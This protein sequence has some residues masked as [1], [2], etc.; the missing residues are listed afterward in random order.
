MPRLERQ[1]EGDGQ[2]GGEPAQWIPTAEAAAGGV[3]AGDGEIRAA[4]HGV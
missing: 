1:A 2:G 4:K 3:A